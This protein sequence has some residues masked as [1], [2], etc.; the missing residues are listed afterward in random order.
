[1]TVSES[2]VVLGA[3]DKGRLRL[4]FGRLQSRRQLR[5]GLISSAV[6]DLPLTRLESHLDP[7]LGHFEQKGFAI[8]IFDALRKLQA[9]DRLFLIVD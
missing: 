5:S 1:M 6:L 8:G 3:E 9:S 2:R 7:G 4:S